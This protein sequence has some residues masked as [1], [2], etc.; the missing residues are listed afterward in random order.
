V[1]ADARLLKRTVE[2]LY[3][4]MRDI[5]TETKN[6]QT[7]VE[8][9]AKVTREVRDILTSFHIIGSFAKWLTT[10]AAAIAFAWG[11]TDGW[12]HK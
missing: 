8:D 10:V 6:T 2:S 1:A 12:F 3:I 9:N 7:W 4:E 11:I 5:R